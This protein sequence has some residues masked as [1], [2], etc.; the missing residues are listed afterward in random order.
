MAA[1]PDDI[2][3]KT[4]DFVKSSSVGE[5]SGHDW[6]HI[7]RVHNMAVYLARKERA[8]L[9]VVELAALLHDIDDW[10]FNAQ[11]SCKAHAWLTQCGL[12]E[13]IIQQIVEVID[14]VSYK[15]A[16]EPNQATTIEAQVVQDAD[17]LDAIG[18][19]GIARTF[20]FGGSH[21]REIYNPHCPPLLHANFDAYKKNQS[22]TINHFYEKLLL[23]KDR[24]NTDTAKA[25]AAER[26]AFLET[27]LA[28]FFAEWNF[29]AGSE[30]QK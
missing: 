18:A 13:N 14:T 20:A 22:H 23:L 19:I 17:R 16:G 8:E 11:G 6:W 15:G 2:I 3:K 4:L 21:G 25:M 1:Y 5:A 24:L 27:F 12:P 9:F 7:Y 26:H 30:T 10:K 28:E 29:N